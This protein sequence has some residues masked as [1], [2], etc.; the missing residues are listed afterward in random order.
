MLRTKGR[1]VAGVLDEIMLSPNL[2]LKITCAEFKL[3]T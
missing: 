3:P 1:L 2:L